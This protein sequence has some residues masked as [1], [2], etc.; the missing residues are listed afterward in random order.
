MG[1]GDEDKIPWILSKIVKFEV[2][3]FDEELQPIGTC[4]PCK[5]ELL[6]CWISQCI[7]LSAVKVW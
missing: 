5:S 3:T 2:I 7:S 4:L 6:A 1:S